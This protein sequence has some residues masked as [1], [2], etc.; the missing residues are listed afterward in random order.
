M[1]EYKL[2]RE[3]A[4]NILWAFNN[5]S[6]SGRICGRFRYAKSFNTEQLNKI[7]KRISESSNWENFLTDELKEVRINEYNPKLEKLIEKHAKRDSKGNKIPVKNSP[8][9]VEVKDQIAW[10]LELETMKKEFP[11][12]LAEMNRV[13]EELKDLLSEEITLKLYELVERPDPDKSDI[14]L[15]EVDKFGINDRCYQLLFTHKI[16]RGEFD[17][18]EEEEFVEKSE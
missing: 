16:I 14:P 18:E 1:I 4:L 5:F 17:P 8:K 13:E 7:Q 6:P 11:E 3:N 10:D 9:A 2:T 12:L 15:Y